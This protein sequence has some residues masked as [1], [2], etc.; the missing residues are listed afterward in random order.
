MEQLVWLRI[1]TTIFKRIC[2]MYVLCMYYVCIINIIKSF[3]L[4]LNFD[5][6]PLPFF[7]VYTVQNLD[8]STYLYLSTKY[9]LEHSQRCCELVL[10]EDVFLGSPGICSQL[11][12]LSCVDNACYLWSMFTILIKG[13]T[14]AALTWDCVYSSGSS[15]M[16]I[17]IST[18]YI[19]CT[20]CPV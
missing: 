3:L 16:S 18:T 15:Y 20:R 2:L 11:S 1:I 17:N 13:L 4:T 9:S 10:F 6:F 5:N 14:A 12:F 8:H 7:N 19:Y